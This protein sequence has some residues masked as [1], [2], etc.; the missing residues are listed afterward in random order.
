MALK[1]RPAIGPG[2]G[3]FESRP[4]IE[5]GVVAPGT[6]AEL[7]AWTWTGITL[8]ACY[9]DAIEPGTFGAMADVAGRFVDSLRS[10]GD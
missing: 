6:D 10:S 7:V 8:A 1:C 2:S 5:Q 4:E 9:R 3:S